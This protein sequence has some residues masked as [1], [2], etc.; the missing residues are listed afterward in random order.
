VKED[1]QRRV[2]RAVEEVDIEKVAVRGI[3]AFPA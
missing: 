3:P 1:E 2:G